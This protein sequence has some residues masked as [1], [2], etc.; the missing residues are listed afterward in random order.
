MS[1]Y[2]IPIVKNT[3]ISTK[4]VSGNSGASTRLVVGG[5]YVQEKNTKYL[6]RVL[7]QIDSSSLSSDITNG[8][9]TNITTDSTA[10]AYLNLFNVLSENPN[11]YEFT[12]D[13]FPLTSLWSEGRGNRED[14]FSQVGYASWLNASST[15][16]WTLSGGDFVIDSNSATQYFET[17]YENLSANIKSIL[18]CWLNGTTANRGLIIKIKISS[19][20]YFEY[21][22]III[23]FSWPRNFYKRIFCNIISVS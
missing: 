8:Y 12:I 4:G 7:L 22:S 20:S 21:F 9:V 23:Y 14:T 11:A 1:F 13:I 10:S 3:S 17:G 18:N 16:A 5:E 6:Y 2:R 15:G 19:I